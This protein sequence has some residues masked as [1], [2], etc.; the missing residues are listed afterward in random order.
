M[1]VQDQALREGGGDVQHSAGGGE[2]AAFLISCVQTERETEK[3]RGGKK[4]TLAHS[5]SDQ[6]SPHSQ[7]PFSPF[8]LC[9]GL[10]D[11]MAFIDMRVGVWLHRTF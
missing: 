11:R 3:E 6:L 10:A 2:A 1:D 8:L 4:K 7:L 5:F 9:D